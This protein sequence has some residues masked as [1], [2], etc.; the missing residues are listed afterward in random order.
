V[1]TRDRPIFGICRYIGIGQNSWF[2]RSQ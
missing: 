1:K 2:D